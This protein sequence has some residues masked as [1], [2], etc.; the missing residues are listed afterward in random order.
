MIRDYLHSDIIKSN[1]IEKT[2]LKKDII[3][4][5]YLYILD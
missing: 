5:I 4:M 3:I 1:I 2:N